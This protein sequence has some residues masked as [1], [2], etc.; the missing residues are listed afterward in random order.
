MKDRGLLP[1]LLDGL[2][3][4]IPDYTLVPVRDGGHFVPWERP[5]EVTEALLDW[6]GRRGAR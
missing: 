3:T 2:E 5:A 1:C 4:L 6:L